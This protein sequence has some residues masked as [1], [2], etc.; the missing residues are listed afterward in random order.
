MASAYMPRSGLAKVVGRERDLRRCRAQFA[1][2]VDFAVADQRSRPGEQRLVA[3]D[4]IDDRQTVVHQRDPANHGVPR[5]IRAAMGQRAFQRRQ[6][7]RTWRRR[8]GGGQNAGDA[9]HQADRRTEQEW[10]M[11]RR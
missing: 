2:V 8:I 5:A 9:A 4:Q 6:R 11:G 1:V 3:G 10:C 7:R